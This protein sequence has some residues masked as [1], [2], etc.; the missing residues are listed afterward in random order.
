MAREVDN[1]SSGEM[2]ERQENVIPLAR[3]PE[4]KANGS[5]AVTTGNPKEPEWLRALIRS[6]GTKRVPKK[7]MRNVKLSFQNAP[8]LKD[9]LR[10]D[11]AALVTRVERPLPWEQTNGTDPWKSRIWTDNDDR[12]SVMWLEQWGVALSLKVVCEAIQAV[13]ELRTFHPVETYL[14][15][16]AWD[17]TKRIETWLIKY[18][19]AEN[20]SIN[21]AIAIRWLV[22]AVAR[23]FEPACQADCML[24][25]EGAQGIGKSTALRVL[26]GEWFTDEIREL[27]RK[28]T[29]MSLA[30]KWVIEFSELEAFKGDNVERLK[31]FLSRSIDRFRPPYGRSVVDVKR[32]CVFAGTTNRHETLRDTTGNRRFWPVLCNHIDAVGLAQD[33]DQLWAEAVALYRAGQ[34]WWMETKELQDAVNE[35]TEKRVEPDP[36]EE[37]IAEYTSKSEVVSIRDVLEGAFDLKAAKTTRRDYAKAAEILR[38]LGFER[39]REKSGPFRDQWRFFRKSNT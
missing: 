17:G 28:D 13:S 39:R 12:E 14:S 34:P 20:I 15:G 7:L 33:R 24:I 8:E 38:H 4:K 26:G 21:R 10:F 32:R 9:A 25:L 16:L 27:G 11:A 37:D 35:A 5:A 19:G 2:Q 22:S 31:A 29:S 36:W 18:L 1:A 30:G 3:K 6:T 23:I